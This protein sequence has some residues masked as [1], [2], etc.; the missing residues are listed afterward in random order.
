[1]DISLLHFIIKNIIS[2]SGMMIYRLLPTLNKTAAKFIHMFIQVL[3]ILFVIVGL[4]AVFDSNNQSGFTHLVSLHS[5]IGMSTVL[6]FA[7]QV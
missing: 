4:Q 5:W 1:M 7:L 6:L 3:T 2:S